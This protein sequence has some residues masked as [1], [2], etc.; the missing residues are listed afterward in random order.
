MLG[1]QL[2]SERELREKREKELSTIRGNLFYPGWGKFR[3]GQ[4]RRG[5][6]WLGAFSLV[7]GADLYSLHDTNTKEAELQSANPFLASSAKKSYNS[8]YNRTGI[9]FGLVLGTYIGSF[10]DSAFFSVGHDSAESKFYLPTFRE[11]G[12]QGFRVDFGWVVRF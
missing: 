10:V 9:L 11:V 3:T 5:G 4:A 6:F 12:T 1:G 8:S 7:L 2:Q